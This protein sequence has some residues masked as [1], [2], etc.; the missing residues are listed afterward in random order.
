MSAPMTGP[1]HYRE[2]ER[3]LRTG[4]PTAALVHATLALVSATV[5]TV[6]ARGPGDLD[7]SWV[8]ILGGDQ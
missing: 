6:A 4:D 2:A 8:P 3:L 5:E 1:E 7:R